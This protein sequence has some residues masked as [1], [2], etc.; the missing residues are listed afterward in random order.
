MSSI[1]FVLDVIW[2]PLDKSDA[3][4]IN[5]QITSLRVCMNTQVGYNEGGATS[6]STLGELCN[7]RSLLRTEPVI[8]RGRAYRVITVV[9]A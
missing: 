2:A 8:S 4:S 7:S 3:T 1:C 9:A 5:M 6:S